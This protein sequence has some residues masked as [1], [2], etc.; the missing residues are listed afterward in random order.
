MQYCVKVW[1]YF[2]GTKQS[3]NI[4]LD[5]KSIDIR[6]FYVN[7]VKFISRYCNVILNDIK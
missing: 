1:G 2:Y 6:V 5:I 4:K 3:V 7:I